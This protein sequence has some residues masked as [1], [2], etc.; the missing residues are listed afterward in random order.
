[1]QCEIVYIPTDTRTVVRTV[2]GI[3]DIRKILKSNRVLACDLDDGLTL[4]YT[5]EANKYNSSLSR[6][7]TKNYVQDVYGD[8]VVAVVDTASVTLLPLTYEELRKY[9]RV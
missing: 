2:S 1:M 6:L 5:A 4:F 7:S 9:K 3:E 8:A